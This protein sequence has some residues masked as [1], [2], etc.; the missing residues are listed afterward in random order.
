MFLLSLG[1]KA[2]WGVTWWTCPS[3]SPNLKTGES[4]RPEFRVTP[5][6][7]FGRIIN[8]EVM[9]DFMQTRFCN[10]RAGLEL[11]QFYIVVDSD[12]GCI[13]TQ[14]TYLAVLPWCRDV[15]LHPGALRIFGAE[16]IQV[17]LSQLSLPQNSEII[18]ALRWQSWSSDIQQ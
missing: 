4:E 1:L 6:T 3:N 16:K 8:C 10:H 18:A 15:G 2:T 14:N 13:Q 11:K 17:Q 7:V 9:E 12:F 5:A